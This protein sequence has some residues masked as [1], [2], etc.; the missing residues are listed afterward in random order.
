MT[1]E[2]P[3]RTGGEELAS[4][5]GLRASHSDRDRVVEL[6]RV[7]AGDGRLTAEELDD[8]LEKALTARTDGELAALTR[9]LPA[10][11]GLAPAEPKQ[12][13][14]IDCRSGSA[15]REGTWVVPQ[16]MQVR[17]RSG[18]VTLDFTEAVISQPLLQIDADVQSG[19][20][21]LVTRPGIEVDAGDVT[22][23]SGAVHVRSPWRPDIPV[24]LQV[25]VSGTVGSGVI[26]VRPPARPRRTWW[27]WLTRQPRPPWPYASALR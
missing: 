6:L 4:L 18:T 15:K 23:R 19:S 21:V 16:R 22:V 11:Q 7:A 20:L 2:I 3:P 26:K 17:S 13:V 8:R 12:L 25:Q 5:A 14:R 24:T 9:D 27:Q 10:G 1:G